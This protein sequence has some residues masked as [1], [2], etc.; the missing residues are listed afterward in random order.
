MKTFTTTVMRRSA[1]ALI[2][3]TILAAPAMAQASTGAGGMATRLT[4]QLEAIFPFIGVFAQ[5]AG[6]VL[7]VFAFFGFKKAKES[8]G[9]YEASRPMVTLL[10]AFGLL[11]LPQVAGIGIG[12][13]FK[14]DDMAAEQNDS[15]F[16]I[17]RQ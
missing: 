13:F 2:G 8:N 10:V 15:K 1:V 14:S 11:G 17:E 4:E 5:L 12:T 6:V 7:L 16:G 3:A 9:Q